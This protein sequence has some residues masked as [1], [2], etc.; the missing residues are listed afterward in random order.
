MKL[1]LYILISV[2]SEFV[3]Q[4][5]YCNTSENNL[6]K[7]AKIQRIKP[8]I[9]FLLHISVFIFIILLQYT[10]TYN[11]LNDFIIE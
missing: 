3:F 4:Q 10:I 1:K 9:Y 6:H 5:S 2:L 8:F 11:S 7:K